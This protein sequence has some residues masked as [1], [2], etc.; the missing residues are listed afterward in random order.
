MQLGPMTP[1]IIC[2]DRFREVK[3]YIAHLKKK[4]IV[5]PL[6]VNILTGPLA[7]NCQIMQCYLLIGEL[8]E[9][10]PTAFNI[11]LIPTAYS[12]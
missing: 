1:D 10:L 6:F 8:Q 11:R 5:P 4:K 3:I 7:Y 2:L 9:T 12:N